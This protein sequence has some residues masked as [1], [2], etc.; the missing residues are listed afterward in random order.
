MLRAVDLGF[1]SVKAI[2]GFR[3]VEYPSA[4]G[5]FRP[6]RFSMGIEGQ[7][8]K[9]KLCVEYEGKSYFIG[10]IAYAQ[11]S[12][13]VTMNSNR[14]TSKEGI[15]IML[16]ALVVLADYQF[17]EVQLVTGLPVN[18]YADLKNTYRDA[19]LGKH[20]IQLF[21]PD[22]TGGRYYAFDIQE[23]KVLPQPIGTIFD[24]VLDA[25]GRIVNKSLA[26]G[27]LGVVDVGKYTVD[28][29]V[30]DAL[31]FIDKSSTSYSDIGLFDAFKELSL[32]LKS[33]GYDIPPD[34]LEPYIRNNKSL[35]GLA[36]LKEGIFEKQSEKIMSRL[37]NTWS[38]LWSFDQIF[39]TGGGAVVLGEHL[40]EHIGT[41]I[42]T[43]C[44][45]P[46]M[47]NCSGYYKLGSKAW[48]KK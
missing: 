25:Q 4:V 40:K 34:S 31:Q 45:K 42:V 44:E 2:C 33:E 32:A 1:G 9:N 14:F 36:E 13:R 29:S 47:S 22:G 6:V 24:E 27:K 43:I 48:G 38:D 39:L 35:N 5:D 23:V 3:S 11:S 26:Q 28:F 7:E 41:D 17:E 21:E 30:S 18:D 8:L 19:L 12:P 16:S 20:N 15:A 46:T 10:D 37:L